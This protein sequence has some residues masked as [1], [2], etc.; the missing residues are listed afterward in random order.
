MLTPKSI[1]EFQ[2]MYWTKY[3]IRLTQDQATHLGTQLIRLVKAVFG[4]DVPKEWK[5]KK[6]DIPGIKRIR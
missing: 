1:K 4:E 3:K 5:P 6:V 2:S